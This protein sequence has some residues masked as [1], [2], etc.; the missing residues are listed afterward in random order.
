MV[1]KVKHRSFVKTLWVRRRSRN[2]EEREIQVVQ[3]SDNKAYV[4]NREE[5]KFPSPTPPK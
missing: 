1:I 4:Q 3:Q 2:E 5:E